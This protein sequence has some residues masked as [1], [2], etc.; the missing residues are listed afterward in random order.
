MK[1]LDSD[2][3]AAKAGDT[4]EV[5]AND[6]NGFFTPNEK[7]NFSNVKVSLYLKKML[8]SIHSANLTSVQLRLK[9]VLQFRRAKNSFSSHW[10]TEQAQTVPSF[11]ESTLTMSQKNW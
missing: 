2:K 1:S 11:P 7:I 9:S 6:N 10:T 4:A 3:S 5:A 8:T